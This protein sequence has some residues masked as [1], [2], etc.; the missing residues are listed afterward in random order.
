MGGNVSVV[1][2][3]IYGSA[4]EKLILV[5]ATGPP[6]RTGEQTVGISLSF[7]FQLSFENFSENM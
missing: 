4:I 1:L 3:A 2:A 5:D 6:S 7:I